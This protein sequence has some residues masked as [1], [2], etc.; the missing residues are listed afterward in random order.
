MT[1]TSFVR[2]VDDDTI[3]DDDEVRES[4]QFGDAL[5][6]KNLNAQRDRNNTAAN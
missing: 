3:N 5:F 4:D 6:K 2:A 1:D